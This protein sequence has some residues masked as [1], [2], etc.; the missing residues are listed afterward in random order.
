M[1]ANTLPN[2]NKT[3]SGLGLLKLTSHTN[4]SKKFKNISIFTGENM[5]FNNY[6]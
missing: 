2:S 6:F 3:L 4:K 1:F 5:V